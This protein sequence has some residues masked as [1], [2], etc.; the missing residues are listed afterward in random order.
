[1]ILYTNGDSFVAGSGL[2]MDLLP[3]WPGDRARTITTKQHQ[4]YHRWITIS[5]SSVTVGPI[6]HK[7]PALEKQR[8][9]PFLLS[10][11]L[12]CEL[13]DSSR[14]GSSFDKIT[15][16]TITDLI[17]LRART[18]E[19]VVAI[20]GETDPFRKEIAIN[21]P[22]DSTRLWMDLHHSNYTVIPEIRGM[23]SYV[24][25]HETLYHRLTEYYK[26]WILLKTFSKTYNIELHWVDVGFTH[27]L[28]QSM[29]DNNPDLVFLR[30]C[31]QLPES[32]NMGDLA[33]TLEFP[34][35]ADGGHFSAAA[36]VLV[37]DKLEKLL[38]KYKQ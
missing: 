27:G 11:K 25:K 8:N 31:A 14:G 17:K 1:M 38:E 35:C 21:D 3:D 22:V 4:S 33:R 24:L 6:W 28:D 30:D 16:V 7:M 29:F 23:Y 32:A 19:P 10:K 18:D 5:R 12:N 37:A 26:N 13:I 15:R 34:Y 9:F 36:H 2:A 20:I